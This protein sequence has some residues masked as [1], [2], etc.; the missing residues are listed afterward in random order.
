[1]LVSFFAIFF[2][3]DLLDLKNDFLDDF[4]DIKYGIKDR[5]FPIETKILFTA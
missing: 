3:I 5:I 2:F 1:L 4:N